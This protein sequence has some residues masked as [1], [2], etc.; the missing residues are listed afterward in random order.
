[1]AST[2]DD[3]SAESPDKAGDPT[4]SA[5]PGGSEQASAP[6]ASMASDETAADETASAEKTAAADESAAA[7]PRT[8]KGSADTTESDTDEPAAETRG[9]GYPPALIAT[10]VA[11]PVALVIAVLVAA[12]MARNMPVER[13]PLVLGPV[14]A[15]AADSEACATL[16][17]ALPADLGEFTKSTLVEPAPPATRAW[18]RPDGGEPI[19]L[20]CGLDRPL[21]FNRASPIQMVNGVQWFEIPDPDADASTWFAVDRA[22]YIALTIPGGSGPTPLQEVSDTITANLPAQPLDPGPLPN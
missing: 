17:P 7:E 3:G 14:P 12:I 16:L 21:E 8:N 4:T 6:D 1:M 9:S 2:P 18:Q 10:A 19:V 13:E 20:R 22:T 5:E 11:L 15:P